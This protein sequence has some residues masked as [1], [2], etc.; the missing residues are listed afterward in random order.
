MNQSKACTK[1]GQIYPRTTDYFHRH[2]GSSDGLA[3]RCKPCRIQDNNDYKINNR[4]KVLESNRKY[5]ATHAEKRRAQEKNKPSRQPAYANAY[6]IA[7][8]AKTAEKQKQASRLWR[9][10]NPEKFKDQ[11]RKSRARIL[12]VYSQ[13]YTESEVLF[14]HGTNCWLCGKEIDLNANRLIGAD[15]WEQ[16]LHLDH[17][18]P[19]GINGPDVLWNVQPAHA[20]CN[21]SRPKKGL[22]Y[23]RYPTICQ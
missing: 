8:Y 15:D 4:D 7:Y 5:N 13:P 18:I 1:C 11:W 10:N 16:S 14:A 12:T 9:K 2:K 23:L 19:I 22:I 21:M 17:V 20:I 6:R 3:H